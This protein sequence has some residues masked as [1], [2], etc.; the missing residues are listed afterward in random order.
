MRDPRESE[1]INRI[2]RRAFVFATRMIWEANHRNDVQALP[3]AAERELGNVT[4]IVDYNRQNLDGTRIPN[5]RG[6]RGTDGARMEKVAAANGWDVIQCMHGTKRLKAFRTEGS[7]ILQKLL[8]EGFSD[9]EF[10]AL[11][12]RRTKWTL[13]WSG[14]S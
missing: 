11:L 4:W 9:F 13:G 5:M 7:G 12:L 2:A 3:D 10:Q 6:L 1:L 14:C 8:E